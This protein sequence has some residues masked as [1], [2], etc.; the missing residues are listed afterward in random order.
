MSP[1]NGILL[2]GV[3]R[4]RLLNNPFTSCSF[5]NHDFLLPHAAHFDTNIVLLFF[6]LIVFE[7]TFFVSFFAL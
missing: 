2:N 7:F 5:I 4:S 6:V 1:K 3:L